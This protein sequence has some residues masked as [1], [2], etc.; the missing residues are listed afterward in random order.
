M[1]GP[2]HQD[3]FEQR[4][5]IAIPQAYRFDRNVAAGFE[6]KRVETAKR[7]SVLVLLPDGFLKQVD[8]D[9]AGLFRKLAGRYAFAAIRVKRIQQPDCKGAGPAESVEAGKSPTVLM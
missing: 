1:A 7:R 3:L 8:F 9:V 2:E 5:Q 4:F 6:I